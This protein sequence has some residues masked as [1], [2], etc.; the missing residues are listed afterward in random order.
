MSYLSILLIF[1]L[2]AVFLEWKF[3]IRLYHSFKE[4]VT[5]IGL[6]FIIGITWDYYAVSQGHWKFPGSGLLGIYIGILPIEEYL[7]FLI[8]PYWGFTI[9]RTLEKKFHTKK[10]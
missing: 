6:L 8:M 5:I 10:K 4:R 1:L 2:S 3:R 9:Y 7:F